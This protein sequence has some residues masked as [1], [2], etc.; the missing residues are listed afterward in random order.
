LKPKIR[1][2]F[3]LFHQFLVKMAFSAYAPERLI[4]Q[5][6]VDIEDIF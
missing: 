2:F 4:S 6:D 5:V 3:Q 1:F